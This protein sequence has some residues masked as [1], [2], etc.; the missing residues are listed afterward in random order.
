MSHKSWI[1]KLI[2]LGRPMP[3]YKFH[4]MADHHQFYLQDGDFDPVAA[5]LD[6]LNT[7]ELLRKWLVVAPGL[8]MV[9]TA[10]PMMVPVEIQI[11]RDPP[12]DDLSRWDAVVESGIVV[13]SGVLYVKGSSEEFGEPLEVASGCHA[14][15]V[16]YGGLG[17]LTSYLEGNDHYKI[18]L[19]PVFQYSVRVVKRWQPTKRRRAPRASA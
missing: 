19:W 11:R 18:A 14:A 9:R 17:T 10:R 13:P 5:D 1:S 4:I 8:I 12:R 15:R 16:Y 7:K 3:R 6:E 2:K